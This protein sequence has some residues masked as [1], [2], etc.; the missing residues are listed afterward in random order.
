MVKKSEWSEIDAPFFST[1]THTAAYWSESDDRLGEERI[2]VCCER[3]CVCC[4]GW[5][6]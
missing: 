1:Y 3:V 5:R 2:G 4:E 6:D